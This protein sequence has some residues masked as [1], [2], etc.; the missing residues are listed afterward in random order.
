MCRVEP[1]LTLVNAVSANWVATQSADLKADFDM[2]ISQGV[3]FEKGHAEKANKL[4]GITV[5][6]IEALLSC[7]KAKI[8]LSGSIARCTFKNVYTQKKSS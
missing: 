8:Y 5:S 4:D 6:Q 1:V 7:V 2:H 3:T